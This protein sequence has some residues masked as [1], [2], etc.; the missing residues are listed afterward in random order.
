MHFNHTIHPVGLICLTTMSHYPTSSKDS[1]WPTIPEDIFWLISDFLTFEE[2]VSLL[3]VNKFSWYNLRLNADFVLYRFDS[4][5]TQRMLTD[6]AFYN[7]VKDRIYLDDLSAYLGES[8][9]DN[10]RRLHG[11]HTVYLESCNDI[12]DFSPLNK[13]KDVVIRRCNIIFLN[14]QDIDNVTLDGCDIKFLRLIKVRNLTIISCNITE[15]YSFKNVDIVTI[16]RCHISDIRHLDGVEVVS[17][18]ACQQLRDFSPLNN[19]K[20][21]KI[22]NC[23]NITHIGDMSNVSHLTVELYDWFTAGENDIFP[24]E[25]YVTV[26]NIS[27]S[28]HRIVDFGPYT[29]VKSLTLVNLSSVDISCLNCELLSFVDT[30]LSGFCVRN[31][32]LAFLAIDDDSYGRNV[33]LRQFR[34]RSNCVIVIDTCYSEYEY[35]INAV[36]DGSESIRDENVLELFRPIIVY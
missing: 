36:M 9:C 29:N 8:F 22:S 18:D 34:G 19:S 33:I 30:S 21:V 31:C 10:I 12:Y 6:E 16:E 20:E 2:C 3:S 27:V 28:N 35:D 17:I 11:V 1:N 14:L 25:S 23:R 4:V 7:R 32:N 26:A 5:T 15:I 13:S 24:G